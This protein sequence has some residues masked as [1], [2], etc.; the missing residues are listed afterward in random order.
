[1]WAR[2]C[3]HYMVIIRTNPTHTL[4]TTHTHSQHNRTQLTQV[5]GPTWQ[6]N[7]IKCIL[8]FLNFTMF[9]IH[10]HSHTDHCVTPALPYSMQ[11]ITAIHAMSVFP[12]GVWV[13]YSLYGIKARSWTSKTAVTQY[14]S[15]IL[16][17]WYFQGNSLQFQL[18]HNYH[19]YLSDVSSEKV[20]LYKHS[21]QLQHIK[22]CYTGDPYIV[23]V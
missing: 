23:Y 2:V 13:N 10:I 18:V 5:S 14:N 17:S 20:N 21:I 11:H 19:T 4:L 9:H 8:H 6:H 15:I 3:R 1:M 22:V 7:E 12:G 16:H